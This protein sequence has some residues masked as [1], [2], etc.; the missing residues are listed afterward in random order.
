MSVRGDNI[1]LTLYDD[2]SDRYELGEVNASR[3]SLTQIGSS[4][5][6]APSNLVAPVD[7]DYRLFLVD[8]TIYLSTGGGIANS[9]D[10]YSDIQSLVE[11]GSEIYSVGID[12]LFR[13]NVADDGLSMT[14]TPI[15]RTSSLSGASNLT[16]AGNYVFF[17]YTVDGSTIVGSALFG[18]DMAAA[19]AGPVLTNSGN[20]LLSI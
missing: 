20:N 9:I 18:G 19:G 6:T 2:G 3:T 15:E 16:V 10:E 7:S 11:A 5:A 12:Q 14:A 4:L 17:L 8:N 1:F 13:L